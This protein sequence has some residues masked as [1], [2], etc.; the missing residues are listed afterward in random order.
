M[1]RVLM[2]LLTLMMGHVYAAEVTQFFYGDVHAMG[3]YPMVG[4]G[5]R[6]HSNQHAFDIGGNTCPL[7]PPQSL[8]V[9]H[10]KSQY[11]FYPTKETYYF[12][13]GLG[14]L[15]EPE[16]IHFSGCLEASLGIEWKQHLFLEVGG[17]V[18]FRSSKNTAPVWPSLTVG[19]GF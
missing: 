11:L 3:G 12:G 13:G 6:M 7:H 17:I 1:T 14:L 15:N 2:T 16:T 5:M 18:P 10:L 19:M 4:G 9:W 8:S